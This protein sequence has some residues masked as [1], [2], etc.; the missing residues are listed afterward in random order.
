M[1][2][3]QRPSRTHV[4]QAK[5]TRAAATRRA[6][7]SQLGAGAATMLALELLDGAARPAQAATATA[8]PPAPAGNPPPAP[9]LAAGERQDPLMRMQAELQRALQKPLEQRRWV[10]VIDLRKCVGCSACTIGCVAENKLPPGV[11]YR[12]VVDEEIGEY[13]NVSRRFL[14]RPCMQCENPP[15]VPVCPVGATYRRNDGVVAI[16]YDQCIGC[17][18]CIVACPYNARTFDAG[19]RYTDATSTISPIERLPAFEYGQRRTRERDT[20]PVGNAR[21]CHFCVHRL[22]AGMLP[23]C[24][25]TCIGRATFFGDASDPEALVSELIAK[26]N[27]MRLKEELGTKPR[28]Y[29]L[30]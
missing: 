24:V 10:M 12:P 19:E 16:N 9:P 22:E 7:L 25:T 18:Y 11:V 3:I 15:C 21:K 6:F 2:V 1:G 28:V 5:S 27:V 26:P 8:P 14:P 20:S 29:Y 4:S 23:A 17:R 13:P 30:L